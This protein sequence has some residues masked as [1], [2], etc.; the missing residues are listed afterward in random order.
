MRSRVC[1]K[2]KVA[3]GMFFTVHMSKRLLALREEPRKGV[4]SLLPPY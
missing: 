2:T 3:L 1:Q 4:L